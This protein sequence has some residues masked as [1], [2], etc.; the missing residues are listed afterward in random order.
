MATTF[1]INVN[2]TVSTRT[3]QDD[4]EV[5]NV[6]RRYY[7]HMSLGPAELEPGQVMLD[8]VLG[9]MLDELARHA[10]EQYLGELRAGHETELQQAH[11]AALNFIRG[12]S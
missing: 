6:L 7:L 12:I 2:G 3:Y 11:E 8:A 1:T 9:G 10:V 4:A 5:I